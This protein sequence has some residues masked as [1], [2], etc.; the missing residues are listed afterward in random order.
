MMG[1][2]RVPPIPKWLFWAAAAFAFVMA[3][4]PHPPPVPGEPNDKVEHIAAFVTLAA[5]GAWSYPRW[6]LVRLAVGLS[7]FGALIE[8]IQMIPALNRD[9]ELLD[10]V[11]DTV[12]AALVLLAVGWRRARAQ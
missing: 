10:W 7:L 1:G 12:A 11:A 8:F 2:P 5:L 9:A 3:V 4:V 6:P